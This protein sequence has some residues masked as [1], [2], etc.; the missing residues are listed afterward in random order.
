MTFLC[1]LNFHFFIGQDPQITMQINGLF[2]KCPTLNCQYIINETMT[3]Q[4]ISFSQFEVGLLITFSNYDFINIQN[5]SLSI[6][7]GGLNCVVS[8]FNLP[9]ITCQL[10]YIITIPYMPI[11]HV[12]GIGYVIN[13]YNIT[14]LSLSCFDGEYNES[15]LCQNCEISCRTCNKSGANSCLTCNSTKILYNG[16]CLG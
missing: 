6:T 7:F 5:D 15:G 1:I 8:N 16:Y 9:N 3:P 14:S 13:S 4:L 2:A 11:I 12:E 10:P